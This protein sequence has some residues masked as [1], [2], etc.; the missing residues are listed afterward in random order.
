MKE[1]TEFKH[2]PFCD[3]EGTLTMKKVKRTRISGDKIAKG[4]FEVWTC[5]KCEEE[6]F[7]RWDITKKPI[8]NTDKA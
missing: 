3:G 7:H 6:F 2:C 5:S 1:K 8:I 4:I